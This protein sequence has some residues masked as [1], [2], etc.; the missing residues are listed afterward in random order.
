V[1][2]H[3]NPNKSSLPTTQTRVKTAASLP[4]KQLAHANSLV[5]QME[6]VSIQASDPKHQPPSQRQPR[7]SATK[8][9]QFDQQLDKMP[10]GMPDEMPNG[11]P[12]EMPDEMPDGLPKQP[13]VKA[14]SQKVPQR[15]P[16]PQQNHS[17]SPVSQKRIFPH[18]LPARPTMDYARQ[19]MPHR[20]N[21][22]LQERPQHLYPRAP[23]SKAPHLAK[24]LPVSVSVAVVEE[25][26]M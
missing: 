21:Q 20:V 13:V 19:D 22:S 11:M 9:A 4:K 2:Q 8:K 18:P 12:D 25:T 23:S 17:N 15:K 24:A 26:C 1:K 3:L 16:R 10:N 6:R 5:E 7:R 14:P